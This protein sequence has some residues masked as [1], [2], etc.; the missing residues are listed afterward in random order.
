MTDR[1]QT[2]RDAEHYDRRIPH[3]RTHHDIEQQLK[4]LYDLI[5]Y[6]KAALEQA[7]RE[8]DELRAKLRVQTAV[9]SVADDALLSRRR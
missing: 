6:L 9:A 1:E 7:E 8:R 5:E 2:R 4:S 3:G